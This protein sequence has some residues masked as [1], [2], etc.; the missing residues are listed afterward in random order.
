MERQETQKLIIKME[1]GGR[2]KLDDSMVEKIEKIDTTPDIS[3]KLRMKN[4]ATFIVTY[5]PYNLKLGN[6]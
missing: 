4:K 5:D 6:I 2:M 3:S 1:F